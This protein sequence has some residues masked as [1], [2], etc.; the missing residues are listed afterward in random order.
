M[1]RQLE[2]HAATLLTG[3]LRATCSIVFQ[4]RI[5]KE[6]GSA[7]R[8]ETVDIM[9]PVLDIPRGAFNIA[10]VG[11]RG[12]CMLLQAVHVGLPGCIVTVMVRG[13]WSMVQ[14]TMAPTLDVC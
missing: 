7:K 3:N 2:N 4:L 5:E 9:V 8:P 14:N 1:T 11:G 13:K 6:K 12:A 10:Q